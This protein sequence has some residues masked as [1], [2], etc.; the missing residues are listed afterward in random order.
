[1]EIL[2]ELPS[3]ASTS[4]VMYV[5]MI[6]QMYSDKLH[7]LCMYYI[8]YVMDMLSNFSATSSEN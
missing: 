3:T 4:R 2:L 7:G 5:S 6:F 8:D 1:M